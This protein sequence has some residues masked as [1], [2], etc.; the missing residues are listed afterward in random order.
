MEFRLLGPLE[1]LSDGRPLPI[2]GQ[3]QR[4]VLALLLLHAN[5]VVSTDRLID[6]VWGARPPKSVDASLQNCISH[7]RNVVGRE[8]I[9]TRP[10]GY[11]LNVDP[12][13]VDALRFERA[14][15]AARTL[16]P[17]ER[18]AALREALALWR[19]PPL[20]DV[21]F[22][23]FGGTEIARIE[24]LRLTA[25]EER[26]DAELALGRHD[27]ILGEIEA[28]ATRYP[29]RE[30]L[31]RQQMLALYRAG[32]QR[33]ALR[34]YQEARLELVEEFG[35]A[36]SEELRALERMIIAHDPALDLDAG[37]RRRRRTVSGATR[38]SRCSSSSTS[39]TRAFARSRPPPWRRSRSS[40]TAT[41]GRFS[42]CWPRSS[43]PSSA[44]R[45]RTTTTRCARFAPWLRR[46]PRCRSGSSSVRPSSASRASRTQRASSKASRACSHRLPPGD[47]LLGPEA[48]RVVPAAVDVVPHESG[49][50]YRVLRFDPGAESFARHPDV[51]IVGRVAE[52]D[53]LDAALAEVERSRSARRVVL[54][55][56]PGIGKTR[57]AQRV[58]LAGGEHGAHAVRP[59]QGVRRR[60]GAAAAPRH[61]RAARAARRCPCG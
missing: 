30:R 7:L 58:P 3:K 32:R 12:E 54:L 47:L 57:L 20:A 24:E 38:S 40:S 5:E 13:R 36:P 45:S 14:L 52:L 59:V 42:S 25:L 50:G 51:P 49:V 41:K 27:A 44:R 48:L 9:E 33:D 11:R 46:A 56:E 8:A 55:G 39:R 19:G 29:V 28:L 15:D 1:A 35:L 18:A 17:P 61:R 4:G 26:I 2:G 43:S 37:D 10:P 23:G 34:V 21:E 53:A 60:R 22:E 16:D 31:R 6:E